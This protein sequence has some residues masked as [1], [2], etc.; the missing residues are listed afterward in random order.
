MV[1]I[2]IASSGACSEPSRWEGG[3]SSWRLTDCDLFREP[4]GSH[5][6]LAGGSEGYSD[7]AVPWDLSL[8]L[9]IRLGMGRVK[10]ILRRQNA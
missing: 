1:N 7:G 8:K 6:S 5:D 2:L 4:L 9:C 10:G 3:R